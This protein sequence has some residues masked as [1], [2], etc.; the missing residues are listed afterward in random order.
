MLASQFPTSHF[1]AA[2]L[3]RSAEICE[4]SE[5]LS[6]CQ[7]TAALTTHRTG[8][9]K[10]ADQDLQRRVVVYKA[11]CRKTGREY[12][13]ITA[14]TM[15]ERRAEHFARARHRGRKT[16]FHREIRVSGPEN[17]AFEHVFTA[18]GVE[19]ACAVE[20]LLIAEYGTEAP[21][22]FNLSSGGEGSVGRVVSPIVREAISAKVKALWADPVYRARMREATKN[23]GPPSEKHVEHLRRLAAEQRGKPR[24][25]EAVEKGRASSVGR[26]ISAETRAK[27]GDAHRGRKWSEEKKA[28]ASARMNAQYAS[29]TRKPPGGFGERLRALYADPEYMARHKAMQSGRRHTAEARAKISAA[30]KRR[31]PEEVS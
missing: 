10:M 22:G 28:A 21:G 11:T 25:R 14:K 5:P 7:G 31:Q 1:P 19:N 26:T 18:F 23:A 9:S 29:G 20:Q 27:I 15:E 3:V 12:V 2:I 4:K 24:S 8:D 16:L 13:G 6:P 17:F 30:R